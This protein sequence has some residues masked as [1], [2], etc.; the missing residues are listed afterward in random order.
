MLNAVIFVGEGIIGF[1]AGSMNLMMDRIYI[2]SDEL[3]LVC[4]YFA[5]TLMARLSKGQ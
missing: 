3:A 1:K 2:Y 4:L 5:Y